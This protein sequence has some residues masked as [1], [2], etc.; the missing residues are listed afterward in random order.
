MKRKR[1]REDKKEWK[2]KDLKKKNDLQIIR[3]HSN[4]T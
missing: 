1:F 4:N 3:G 2:E